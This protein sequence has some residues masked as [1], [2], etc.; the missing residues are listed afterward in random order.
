MHLNSIHEDHSVEEL[1]EF[2]SWILAIGDD[3]LGDPDDGCSMIAIPPELLI[4][5]FNDPSEAI[6]RGRAI[7]TPYQ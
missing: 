6:V 1:K 7:L 2:A 3:N 5:E 4:R